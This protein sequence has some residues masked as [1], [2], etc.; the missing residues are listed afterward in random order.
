MKLRVPAVITSGLIGRVA[1]VARRR[2]TVLPAGYRAQ[3][4]LAVLLFLV[5]GGSG[6]KLVMHDMQALPGNAAFR[7][8]GRVVTTQQL[9]QR[10]NLMEFLYGLQQPTDPHQLDLFK[11][12]VA[13]AV[14]V[15]G[16]V[17]NTA[18][19]RGIVIADKEASDQLG[20]LIQDNSWKDRSTLIQTL[21][22]RGLSEQGV[23]DEIKRQQANSRLF[24]QVTG[25]VKASTDSEAQ[26]YYDANKSQM[27]SPEQ[28]TIKNIV[29]STQD[30]AEQ[31]AKQAQSGAD[32]GALA[33]QDSIDGS[34]KSKGGSLGTVSADQLNSAYAEVAFQVRNG[35][36][37]G[38]VQ[39]P[40]GWNVGKVTDVHPATPL[41][42][43]QLKSVIKTKLDNDAKLKIWNAFLVKRI[44]AAHVVYAPAYRPSDPDAPPQAEPSR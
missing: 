12:S 6:T 23:L 15:G 16:I 2:S 33:K 24:G 7:S 8:S 25:S 17:D 37:F 35:S 22:A 36:V 38:P 28:R 20:K 1:G 39:T 19:A 3:G 30:Q 31:V 27:V 14:A 44:K 9:Q 40:Q 26:R 4:A 29:V 34:T 41:S 13:K 10:V 43:A 11:R 18:R 5:A 21:G 32:F 42:F